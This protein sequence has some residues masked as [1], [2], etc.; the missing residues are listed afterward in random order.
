MTS[1]T[2]ED[3]RRYLAAA[4]RHGGLRRN[5]YSQMRA[6][7]TVHTL[8]REGLLSCT[9]PEPRN[10]MFNEITPAGRQ[11]LSDLTGAGATR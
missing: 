2:N 9:K 3:R 5:A 4:Q 8:A 1:I 6:D 7:R 11:R 10:R